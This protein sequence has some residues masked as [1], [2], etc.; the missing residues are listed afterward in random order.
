MRATNHQ[1][2]RSNVM[3]DGGGA[4]HQAV[5]MRKISSVA[6]AFCALSSSSDDDCTS[7]EM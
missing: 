1:E 5:W 7:L 4:R 6:G 3:S 2:V